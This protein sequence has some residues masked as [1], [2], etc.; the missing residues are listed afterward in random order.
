MKKIALCF[1]LLMFLGVQ[2]QKYVSINK[3]IQVPGATGITFDERG[4]LIAAESAND[5]LNVFSFN[6]SNWNTIFYAGSSGSGN[7][8]LDYPNSVYYDKTCSRLFVTELVNNRVS[9][10]TF[11]GMN[12]DF[13]FKFSN[14]LN[15]TWFVKGTSN[16][17]IAVTSR[18]GGTSPSRIQLLS[19]NGS[20]YV[21]NYSLGN[22]LL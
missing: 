20:N 18:N 10:F 4:W 11:N 17:E 12:Y 15:F 5:R 22:G 9:V 3:F 6:G 1:S 2:A 16:G 13:G 8:N 7:G 21:N 14:S 19:F